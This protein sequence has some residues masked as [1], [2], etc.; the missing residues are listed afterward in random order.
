MPRPAPRQA[1]LERGVWKAPWAGP[2]GE[3]VFIVV[4][5]KHRLVGEPVLVPHGSHSMRLA[6]EMWARLEA[7]DPVTGGSP[8]HI[9]AAHLRVV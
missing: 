2:N 5:S 6:D 9:R 8:A 4:D 1:L 3:L 7:A